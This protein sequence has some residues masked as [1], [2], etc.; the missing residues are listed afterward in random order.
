[1]K[2]RLSPAR[3]A[4]LV[5][6][7]SVCVIVCL[8]CLLPVW[9]VLVTSLSSK[10][11]IISGQ[12]SLWPVELTLDNYRYVMKDSQFFSS[13][14]ISVERT[15][16]A[17]AIQM[18]LTVLA[19]YPMS[20][21]RTKFGARQFYVWF[22]MITMMFGGGMIPTYIVVSKTGLIDSI[23]SLILPGAV[24]VFNVILLQN[25]MKTL[26]ESLSESASLDGAGHWRTLFQI[27]LPL[28]A[29]SL[30]TLCL[31]VA[32]G[33]WNAWFDGMLYINDNL[34]LPLQTYLRSLI[35]E[36]NMDQIT[37][38]DQIAQMVASVGA[39]TAKI[40]IA[41]VPILAV[42]PFVQKHFIKGI[43]QGSVK[44]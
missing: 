22:F 14:F 34:K 25:Y 36:V 21:S 31:F 41:M 5:F 33:N 24:P 35:V 20:I 38:A 23:W 11:A 7:H 15:V 29:P 18:F 4:Y 32:V 16:L 2:M 8:F 9:H 3:K 12:V 42:Y 37:D 40:F 1:M 6:N 39:N 10:S 26:P 30:A 27:I 44:E 17:L 28:C 19:A 43:V 13:F